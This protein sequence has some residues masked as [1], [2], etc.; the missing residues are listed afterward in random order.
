MIA[1]SSFFSVV[2]HGLSQLM[3]GVLCLVNTVN[4]RVL[5]L[6]N[7]VKSDSS[8]IA[9]QL[10]IV[11]LKYAFSASWQVNSPVQL[12]FFLLRIISLLQLQISI[13]VIFFE[14]QVQLQFCRI[15]SVY[16]IGGR[17]HGTTRV[18]CHWLR[19]RLCCFIPSSLEEESQSRPC[20]GTL[21]LETPNGVENL[22]DHLRM[23]FEPIEVVRRGRHVYDFVYDFER[24]QGEEIKKDEPLRDA[25]LTAIPKGGGGFPRV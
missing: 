13:S 12:Q 15:N 16:V 21:D 25:M 4:D 24:Q 22:L 11:C 2:V 19:A 1:L 5:R 7:S 20:E 18:T 23:H 3:D 9:S 8:L 17:V 6:Q 10:D 14:L